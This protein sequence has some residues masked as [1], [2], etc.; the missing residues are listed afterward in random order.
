L[1]DWTGQQ[2]VFIDESGIN[3][4]M[5]QP[6]HGYG[7]KGQPIPYPVTTQR[8]D[9]LSL[10]PALTLDGYIACNVYKGGVNKEM[11]YE[12]IEKDVLPR[13]GPYPGPKSIIV[14]DN[15]RIHRNE[16]LILSN[17]MDTNIITGA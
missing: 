4:K 2:L 11:F 17:F 16:V 14:M 15:A 13:C 7:P 12:F 1:A 3:S 8:A 6:T 10:L 5:S 9:N